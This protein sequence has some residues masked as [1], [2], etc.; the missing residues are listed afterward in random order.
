LPRLLKMLQ[1]AQREIINAAHA[2]ARS[3]QA[4]HQMAS[5]E[6][7]DASDKMMHGAKEAEPGNKG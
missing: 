1:P 5:D 3:Q 4:I 2:I 6:T 7:C